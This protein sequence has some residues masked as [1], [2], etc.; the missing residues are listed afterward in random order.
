MTITA[1]PLSWPFGWPRTPAALRERGWQFKT[2]GQLVTFERARRLL[3]DELGRMRAEDAILSTNI[4]LRADGMPR[5]NFHTYTMPDPGV[6]IYFKVRGRSMVMAQDAFDN[7]AANCRSLGLAV[8]AM[9]ALERHGGGAMMDRAFTGF[10]ALPPK[11]T[12]W[13]VLDI[14]PRSSVDDI[15][16]AHRHLLLEYHQRGAIDDEVAELNAARDDALRE[17]APP[18]L[19]PP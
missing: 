9:R 19:P 13:D 8:E 17:V 11:R 18:A 1:F 5:S 2:G 16:A 6:A 15:R 14:R 7:P 12:C 4:P 10:L 3:V